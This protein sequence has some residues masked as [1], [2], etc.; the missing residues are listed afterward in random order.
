MHN[1]AHTPLAHLLIVDDESAVRDLLSRWLRDEGYSCAL[2]ESPATAWTYLQEHPVDLATLDIRMPGGSGLDLL[3]R[4]KQA[5]PDTAAI[6][7]SGEGDTT[8]AIRALTGGASGYLVKPIERQE[9]IIQVQNA[10]ERRRLIV[11]NRQQTAELKENVLELALASRELERRIAERT[12]DLALSNEQLR[13]ENTE[14]QRAQEDVRQLNV[15][16]ERRVQDRTAQLEIAN[17]ELETFSYSVSHDLKAPL[18]AI[19]GFS[20]ALLEDCE[21]LLND[22]GHDHLQMIR[23]ATKRMGELINDLLNLARVACGTTSGELRY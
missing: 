3:D 11:E 2:A 6:M 16:L 1:V 4:I 19:D 22:A 8:K 14:R 23:A 7:L 21:D 20:Q 9:L 10:L 18:R 15:T 5:M 12:A 17:K 13:T